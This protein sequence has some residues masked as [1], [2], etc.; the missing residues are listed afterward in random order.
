MIK[1][2]LFYNIIFSCIIISQGNIYNKIIHMDFLK[3]N[4][5][6][7]K[8]SKISNINNNNNYENINENIN[9]NNYDNNYDNNDI[10]YKNETLKY[11]LFDSYL[12]KNINKQKYIIDNNSKNYDSILKDLIIQEYNIFKKTYTIT[13]N[14]NSYLSYYGF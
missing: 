1:K 8:I 7:K 3:Y 10:C 13:L 4:Y 11:N 14:I 6:N 2:I 9:D 5:N 12:N